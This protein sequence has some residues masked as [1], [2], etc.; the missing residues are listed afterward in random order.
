M[1]NEKT[2]H[3]SRV[4]KTSPYSH[5]SREVAGIFLAV[6]LL[7]VGASD[8]RSD[9]C[10]HPNPYGFGPARTTVAVPLTVKKNTPCTVSFTRNPMAYFK[11][12]VI[13]QP[14]GFYGVNNFI[15][16]LYRPPKDYVG[17]DYFE[18]NLDY[19]RLGS[20]QERLQAILQF[21]VKITE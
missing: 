2:D 13:K 9:E 20:G 10:K 21:S 3:H 14:R 18:L 8:A 5:C 7:L 6:L 1:P 4:D 19:Q 17:D 11:Q 12:K 16:G 15:H